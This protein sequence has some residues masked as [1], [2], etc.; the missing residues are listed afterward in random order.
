MLLDTTKQ[1]I[2][3]KIDTPI[4]TE[5]VLRSTGPFCAASQ[6]ISGLRTLAR[7]FE[8]HNPQTCG[9]LLARQWS[10]GWLWCKIIL[11]CGSVSQF[12]PQVAVA[13]APALNCSETIGFWLCS[14]FFSVLFSSFLFLFLTKA[15]FVLP[16]KSSDP[17]CKPSGS[18]LVCHQRPRTKSSW[19]GDPKRRAM[20]TAW[21]VFR[22]RSGLEVCVGWLVFFV[23]APLFGWS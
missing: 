19:R 17:S 18:G 9:S 21:R 1:G 8:R 11:A 16:L 12:G 5:D 7:S 3:A 13:V 23:G 2:P 10:S 15:R 14:S 4:S 6:P 22:N 20:R